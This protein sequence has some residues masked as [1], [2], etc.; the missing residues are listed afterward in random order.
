LVIKKLYYDARSTNHQKKNLRL[1]LY[2]GTETLKEKREVGG[3]V[4]TQ[5][6]FFPEEKNYGSHRI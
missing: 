5:T 3:N 6:A 4:Q 1:L 2:L